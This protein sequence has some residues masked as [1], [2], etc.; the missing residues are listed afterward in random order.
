MAPPIPAK[1]LSSPFSPA[2]ALLNDFGSRLEVFGSAT[3]TVIGK[4]FEKRSEVV[5]TASASRPKYSVGSC[6]PR[7][8]GGWAEKW[9]L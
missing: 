2:V 6:Y 1:L 8:V 7:L 5:E 3:G 4:R 9:Q